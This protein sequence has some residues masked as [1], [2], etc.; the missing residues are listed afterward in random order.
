MMSSLDLIAII[1][2]KA[3]KTDRVSRELSELTPQWV[4]RL[5]MYFQIVELL[6]EVS[7]YVEKY[8]PG[9]LKYQI[10]REVNKK[11]GVEEIIMIER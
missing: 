8:E 6:S 10:T 7:V 4:N 2:P 5:K 11:N 9:T 1:S 3:G